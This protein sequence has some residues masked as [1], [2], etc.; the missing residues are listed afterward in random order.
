VADRPVRLGW[1]TWKLLCV[2]AVLAVLAGCG[3]DVGTRPGSGSP[4]AAPSSPAG[5]GDAALTIVVDDGK[6]A[7]TRWTLTCD[8]AGGDHPDPAEACRVLRRKGPNALSP[9]PEGRFCTQVFGGPAVA[10]VT[11]TWRGRAVNSH[12]DLRNGC[13][14]A[15]WKALTGLLPAATA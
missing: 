4:P 9:V 3:D 14:I 7:V 5:R 15:R 2:P 1:G 13:E 8:P 10:T 6:G 11:G 12:F